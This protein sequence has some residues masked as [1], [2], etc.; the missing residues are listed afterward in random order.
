MHRRHQTTH[1]GSIH[2]YKRR[3]SG[4]SL[5]IAPEAVEHADHPIGPDLWNRSGSCSMLLTY[6]RRAVPARSRN[7]TEMPRRR[8]AGA[9]AAVWLEPGSAAPPMPQGWRAIMKLRS[10]AGILF[11]RQMNMTGA[12][13][14]LSTPMM[15]WCP[16]WHCAL[17]VGFSCEW[18]VSRLA[19]T[20]RSFLMARASILPGHKHTAAG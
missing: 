12:M 17:T 13:P 15:P 2:L 6:R 20:R 16:H 5:G 19:N 10:E 3:T 4:D 1:R 11:C 18:A 7:R 14:L 9:S 8:F